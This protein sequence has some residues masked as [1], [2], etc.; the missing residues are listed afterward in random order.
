[1]SEINFSGADLQ[2]K[3]GTEATL[4]SVFRAIENDLKRTGEVVCQFK[5]NGLTLDEAS[6]QRLAA[7]LLK[8]VET[9][10]VTSQKPSDILRGVLGNWC[11]QL[12]KM[13][14]KNDQLSTNLRFKGL[15]GQLT[16]LIAFIDDCQLLVD[17]L[18]SID[19]VFPHIDIVQSGTWKSAQRQMA[20]A[21]GEALAAFQKKDFTQLADILEYDMGHTLQ[22]WWDILTRLQEST[23][24]GS[25]HVVEDRDFSGTTE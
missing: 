13:I 18:I 2:K 17:S 20:L 24:N 14:E 19:Q 23:G 15:D 12:P 6:E 16:L 10:D 9:L 22:V 8:E 5:V 25:S 7:A 21:I 4:G 11:L 3:F 1:M